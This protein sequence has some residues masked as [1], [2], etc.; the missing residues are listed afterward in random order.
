M[1]VILGLLYFFVVFIIWI[2]IKWQR[3]IVRQKEESQQS[4][5]RKKNQ[6]SKFDIIL[7][8]MF[9]VWIFF[10]SGFLYVV[11]YIKYVKTHSLPS[12][13]DLGI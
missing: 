2:Y 13:R 12:Q 1:S 3:I 7:P 9:N 11:T 5:K 6:T 8:L 10:I 4:T